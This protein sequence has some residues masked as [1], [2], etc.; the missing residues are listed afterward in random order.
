MIYTNNY[1]IHSF[2]KPHR[3]SSSKSPS[4]ILS[5]LFPHSSE[6]ISQWNT[7][8]RQTVQIFDEFLLEELS[9][10]AHDY[11][12]DVEFHERMLSDTLIEARERQRTKYLRKKYFSLWRTKTLD[13]KEERFILDELQ[14]K[15]HF[16]TNEQLFEFLTGIQ[17]MIEH[18]LTVDQ[19]ADIFKTRRYLK[20]NRSKKISLLSQLYFEEFLHE[21]FHSIVKESNDELVQRRQLLTNALEKQSNLKR[22]HYLR[23][24]YFSLWKRRSYQRRKA[25]ISNKRFNDFFQIRQQKKFKE[26]HQQYL[27]IKTS[28]D[29]LTT[30]L[31]QIQLFIDKLNS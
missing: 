7:R 27:T 17:L 25:Q 2:E 9:I 23:M 28:F 18:D 6:L 29:Q 19:T 16:L 13:A 5:H 24:K 3:I 4:I 1:S 8:T 14:L 22:E 10:I 11:Y 30:D 20:Q 12:N 21:E 15:Y 26:N 31:N